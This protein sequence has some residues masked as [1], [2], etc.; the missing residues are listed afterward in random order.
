MKC[1]K[2]RMTA[3]VSAVMVAACCGMSWAQ[4]NPN[5]IAP[6][7]RKARE[8]VTINPETV[9]TL[10][11]LNERFAETAK[12]WQAKDLEAARGGYRDVLAMTNAPSHYRSYAH[13]R[14]AQSYAAERNT[15][16]AKAEYE[17]TKTNTAYPP[18]HRY[19]AE[20]TLNEMDRVAQGLPARDV[21][22]SRTKTPPV[23]KFAV[24]FFVAP[25]GNDVNPGT[26]EKPFASLEKARDAIRALKS[27]GALLGPVGVSLLPGEYPVKGTFELTSADSGTE[28]API[29]YRADKKGTAVLY[30]GVRLSG[31]SPVTDPAVLSRL[32]EE[33]RGKVFQCDLKKL[34]IHDYGALTERGYGV[35]LRPQVELYCDGKL[36][37]LARWPNSGFVN[38]EKIVDPGSVAEKKSSV[39]EYL[40]DRHARWTKASDGWLYGY[41]A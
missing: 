4:N 1:K 40:D 3:L 15:A 17:K 9:K 23:G 7:T 18:V 31:F 36:Q 22:A 13:L 25:T 21:M 29:L 34:G 6:G 38:V 20:E 41:W 39:F 8:S 2:T 16:A 11:L 19:E 12:L 35:P 10:N 27:K 26:K 32:P 30:G 37:T 24:E 33:A 5:D 14:I 28:T